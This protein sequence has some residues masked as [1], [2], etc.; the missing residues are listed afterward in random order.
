MN[1]LRVHYNGWGEHWPLG[2]LAEFQGGTY[3]EYSSEALAAGIEFSPMHWP[4]KRGAHR[5][6]RDP[7]NGLPGLIADSLPD[8]WGMLLMDRAFRKAGREPSTLSPLDRLAFIGNRGMGA[9][10][11]EPDIGEQ[12]GRAHV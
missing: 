6:P 9:L 8:G 5:A 3:F 12:I 1:R 7:F 11:F 4:L 2:T 10:T